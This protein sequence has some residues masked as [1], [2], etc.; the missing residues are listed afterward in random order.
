MERKGSPG[1]RGG[2]GDADLTA[3]ISRAAAGAADEEEEEEEKEE[4][5]EEEDKLEGANAMGIRG[6]RKWKLTAPHAI[7]AFVA[8]R[9]HFVD[10]SG[11]VTFFKKSSFSIIRNIN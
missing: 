1:L 4:E 11:P 5:G 3:L 2:I 9:F 6:E 10:G 8:L 7:A